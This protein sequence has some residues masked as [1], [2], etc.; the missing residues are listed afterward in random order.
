MVSEATFL[1][2]IVDYQ[3]A[4][5]SG[6]TLRVQGDRRDFREAGTEVLLTVPVA[7]CVLMNNETD[8]TEEADSG[9]S[10]G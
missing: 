3:I 4:I 8:V 7:D 6:V 10:V 1:G 5:G 9:P 2:N